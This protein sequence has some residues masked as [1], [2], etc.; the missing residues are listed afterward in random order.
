[1]MNFFKKIYDKFFPGQEVIGL[2]RINLDDSQ[3]L[4][5]LRELGEFS[6][7]PNS[8]NIGDMLIASATLQWFDANGI[9]YKR[10][11]ENETPNIF[12]YGG[13]GAWT[14]DYIQWMGPLMDKMKQAK[15]VVI[16]PSSFND[17]P[18]FIKI[19]DERFIVFCREKKSYDYLKSQKTKAT[20]LLD[21]DMAL[22]LSCVPD[23]KKIPKK[24]K[25]QYKKMNK[26]LQKLP[27]TADLFRTDVES[28]GHYKSDFDISDAFG[29]FSPYE[30]REI[31]DFAA[32]TM[33]K[34]VNKFDKVKT[35]RLHVGIASMFVGADV[36][37]Y[38]NSYGKISGV[39]ENSL[40]KL[41]NVI[42][43]YKKD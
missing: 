9:K 29:W 34:M 31:I 2:E 20:I 35:D 11:S 25:K 30:K 18:E 36:E 4:N 8:G 16:L 14:R 33:L 28:H 38:D 22:R 1:M 3:L 17:V 5:C 21:H 41:K 19:L 43:K 40:S 6:Y 15:K 24:Y 39:Y 37:L 42:L 26:A 10:T 23:G 7:M 27:K 12:V 13:G 32:R